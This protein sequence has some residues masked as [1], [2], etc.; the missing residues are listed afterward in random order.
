MRKPTRPAVVLVP[1]VQGI[2]SRLQKRAACMVS[3][4]MQCAGIVFV[5]VLAKDVFVAHA[6]RVTPQRTRKLITIL[7][8]ETNMGSV[9][10]AIIPF[11]HMC[12]ADEL[13][14]LLD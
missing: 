2:L 3:Y 5:Q 12:L 9:I 13:Q 10:T 7:H 14:S 8:Y 1:V 11:L 6:T 4:Q